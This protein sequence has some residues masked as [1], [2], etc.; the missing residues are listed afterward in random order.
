MEYDLLK[1]VSVKTLRN[2]L[3]LLHHFSDIFCPNVSLFLLGHEE[4]SAEIVG[5]DTNKLR[6][7]LVSNVKEA[8]FRKVWKVYGYFI[9]S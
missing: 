2:R 1:D 7:L 6:G 9:H 8:A 4:A 3:V 5:F